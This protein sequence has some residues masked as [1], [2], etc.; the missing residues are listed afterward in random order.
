M[1]LLTMRQR[2]NR[3]TL[4]LTVQ[5]I[6]LIGWIIV[7]SLFSLSPLSS[8]LSFTAKMIVETIWWIATLVIMF[9]L[10]RREYNGFVKAVLDLEDANRR[11][12]KATSDLLIEIS[13][14]AE[15]EQ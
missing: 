14:P 15:Q 6:A 12:R 9:L 8:S 1:E 13:N 5:F 10:F 3:I 4:F 7:Q 2:V 11:L